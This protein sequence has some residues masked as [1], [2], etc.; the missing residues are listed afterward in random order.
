MP[1]SIAG[2][3]AIAFWRDICA[4]LCFRHHDDDVEMMQVDLRP[5]CTR[6][7][8]RTRAPVPVQLL[9]V[10]RPG[11]AQRTGADAEPEIS[12]EAPND[13]AMVRF[14]STA[15]LVNNYV[16]RHAVDSG[17]RYR[18]FINTYAVH[19]DAWDDFFVVE[20][21][22]TVFYKLALEPGYHFDDRDLGAG[23]GRYKTASNVP[24]HR[25]VHAR[26]REWTTSTRMNFATMVFV[27]DEYRTTNCYCI[28]ED[29]LLP[30][31][32][33]KHRARAQRGG[34]EDQGVPH[35]AVR[36]SGRHGA[37]VVV[38]RKGVKGANAVCHGMPV[39]SGMILANG[40]MFLSRDAADDTRPIDV[41]CKSACDANPDCALA[42]SFVETFSV[43]QMAHALPPPPSPPA[44]PC[45]RRQGCPP[46]RPCR[47]RRRPT[48]IVGLRTWSPASYNSAPEGPDDGSNAFFYCTVSQP[49]LQTSHYSLLYTP[50]ASNHGAFRVRRQ[51]RHRRHRLPRALPQVGL[52]ALHPDHGAQHD[53]PGH[54]PLERVPVRVHAHASPGTRW[55]RA[56]RPDMLSGL[57]LLGEHF[58]YPGHDDSDQGFSRFL[59][60]RAEQH[61]QAAPAAH[62]A[63]T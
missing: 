14:L 24:E 13:L 2:E 4:S 37:N 48:A 36:G 46:F 29:L 16:G 39:G 45:R 31:H 58:V 52:A 12:H 17:L 8:R 30:E 22:S 26:V 49:H 15:K 35:Q 34:Q 6:A 33:A 1:D 63:T 59:S 23:H 5:G 41:Q 32:D 18:R 7:T 55:S 25:R 27:E 10:R 50:P 47:P 56:T 21:Q 62:G 19:R 44:P 54:L 51:R 38:Y 11:Q 42:H 53:R 43:Q 3:P 61:G 60:A 9:R 20:E 28:A 40:S 57:G